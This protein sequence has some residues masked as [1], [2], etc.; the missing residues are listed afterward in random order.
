MEESKV[1]FH[2]ETEGEFAYFAQVDIGCGS[3]EYNFN[4]NNLIDATKTAVDLAV[5]YTKPL[6]ETPGRDIRM[7]VWR[8]WQ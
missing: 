4:A 8:S 1:D 3:R 7:R 2:D 6:E 5:K